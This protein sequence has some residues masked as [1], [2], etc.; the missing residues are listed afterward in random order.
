[1]CFGC[2]SLTETLVM[3]EFK[4][5]NNQGSIISSGSAGKVLLWRQLFNLLSKPQ[6]M[7]TEMKYL[8]KLFIKLVG[9]IMWNSHCSTST[10]LLCCFFFKFLFLL[11]DARQRWL[12][13]VS[14]QETQI[15]IIQCFA[16]FLHTITGYWAR[17]KMRQNHYERKLIYLVMDSFS[18]YSL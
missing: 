13:P 1:M 4:N 14:S 17:K 15:I 9:N 7:S 16:E 3:H 8:H 2:A 11:F 5:N 10:S 12:A 18:N 6:T